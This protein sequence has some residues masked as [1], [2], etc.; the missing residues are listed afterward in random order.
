MGPPLPYL[1]A[2][3]D[4]IH[5]GKNYQWPRSYR[6]SL[7]ELS[8]VFGVPGEKE[9]VVTPLYNQTGERVGLRFD[10]E[11]RTI[12]LRNEEIRRLLF[13]PS[14]KFRILIGPEE[15][16]LTQRVTLPLATTVL[17]V[18]NGAGHGVGLSQW[19]AAAMAAQGYTYRQILRHYYGP[20][21]RL[22]YY[23]YLPRSREASVS[24][25]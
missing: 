11:D 2:V 1:R 22:E 8:R 3:D 15:V 13:L 25:R 24:L 18:G 7:E 16:E 19:G 4:L 14:A 12:Q 9:L 6:F 21:V 10:G 23:H 17:F 20:A 5:D